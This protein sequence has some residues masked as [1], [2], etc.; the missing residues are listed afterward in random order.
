VRLRWLREGGRARVWWLV[1]LVIAA[2]VSWVVAQEFEASVPWRMAAAGAAVVIPVLLTE[3]VTEVFRQD[4]ERTKACLQH[5][6][7]YSRR[8]GIPKVGSIRDLTILG[9]TPPR[10]S[11]HNE[12][13]RYVPRDKDGDLD[14]L[15]NNNEFVLLIGDSKA[16]KSRMAAEAMRRNFPERALIIPDSADSLS[17]L[18][19]VGLDFQGSVV[20]L[21]ELQHYLEK[22]GLGRLLDY[23]AGTDA[24]REVVV[25]ATIREKAY[26]PYIPD[27]E[28]DSPYW[29]VLKRARR[30]RIDR[31]LSVNERDRAAVVFD[32]PNMFA[33]MGNYGLAEYLSAGP[34]LL[35]RLEN[36]MV[37]QPIGAMVVLAAADWSRTG[38][39]RPIPQGVLIALVENYADRLP[40]RQPG[41]SDISTAIAWAQKAVY[42]ASQLLSPASDGFTEGY[43]KLNSKK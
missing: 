36:G 17:A 31:L 14:A 40:I 33:A 10:D 32:D 16:G 37:S 38:L 12:Q 25:L 21:D 41:P 4:D 43:R 30:L 18:L 9:V 28:M 39:T 13:D 15:L 24:P 11:E 27:G 7:G 42:G 19:D 20:W 1:S 3:I 5:L 22:T 23:L 35:E 2:A 8:R 29:A 34:D 26:A 6:R